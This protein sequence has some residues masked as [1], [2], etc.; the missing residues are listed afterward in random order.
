VARIRGNPRSA[1]ASVPGPGCSP[2]TTSTGVPG[3][4]RSESISVSARIVPAVSRVA[5]AEADGR[6]AARAVLGLDPD[7]GHPRPRRHPR[8]RLSRRR[9][10]SMA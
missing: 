3:V 7:P 4:A 1:S 2:H 10:G 8:L 9:F 5:V 6:Q